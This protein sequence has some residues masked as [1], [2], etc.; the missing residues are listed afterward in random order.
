W[1]T[2]GGSP[3]WTLGTATGLDTVLLNGS[4]DSV[5][6]AVNNGNAF[7]LFA[8]DL[9][10]TEFL[11]G[12]TFTLTASFS[13]GS[14]AT[15]NATAQVFTLTVASSNPSNGAAITVNPNDNGNQANGTTQFTRIYNGNAAVTLTAAVTA[16]G[17]NFS[18]WSGC[19]SG[20][21][22]TCN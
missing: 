11:N 8:A 9:N 14:T 18:S 7:K 17:N 21:G 19:D 1:D 10:N 6:I 13:D 20:S 5:S 4:D 2:I 12:R 16:G 22:S 15:A 3:N